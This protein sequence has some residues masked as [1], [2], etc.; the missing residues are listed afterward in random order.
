ML[1]F[2]KVR[3]VFSAVLSTIAPDQED[4]V[5]EAL[6]R[7]SGYDVQEKTRD[8]VKENASSN[9]IPILLEAYNQSES[10]HTRLQILYMFSRHF[11]KQELREMIPG[12]SC[13]IISTL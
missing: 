1:L 5:F 7:S 11:S 8:D 4:E 6:L 12:F 13:S 10:R 2:A 9:E 3:Q